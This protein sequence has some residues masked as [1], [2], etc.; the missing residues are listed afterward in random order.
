MFIL[1]QS[2]GGF[3]PWLVS[4]V[5]FGLGSLSIIAGACCSPYGYWEAKGKKEEHHIL[6]G[7]VLL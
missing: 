5:A 2:V 6:Q 1:S 4:L 7:H 3:S